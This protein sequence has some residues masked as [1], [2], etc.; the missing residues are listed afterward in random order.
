MIK[1]NLFQEY[2]LG[3]H[4]KQNHLIYHINRTK[5]KKHMTSIGAVKAYDKI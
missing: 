2:K 1:E 5:K 4:T 3:Q